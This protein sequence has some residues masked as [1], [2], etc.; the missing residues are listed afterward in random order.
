M[1][2]PP[3]ENNEQFVL[4]QGLLKAAGVRV[5]R[6]QRADLSLGLFLLEDLGD[7]TYWSALQEG[8]VDI[9]YTR[10]L[11]ALSDMQALSG[12]QTV[13]P[14]YDDKELQRELTICPEWFFARALSMYL[15]PADE[16]IF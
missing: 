1:V 4:V 7:V 13:L 12:A 14:L 15:G 11:I 9:Y 3:T 8:D 5:P 16:A 2:S 6:L 10:A